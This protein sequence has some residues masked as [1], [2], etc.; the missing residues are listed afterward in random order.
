MRRHRLALAALL[1]V[2]CGG[3][4]PPAPPIGAVRVTVTWPG[5]SPETVESA[6]LTPLEQLT[7]GLPDVVRIDGQAAEGVAIVELAARTPA[8]L[9]RL[10]EAARAAL[11]DAAPRLPT[12]ASAPM[13]TKAQRTLPVLAIVPLPATDDPRRADAR[14]RELARR[15]E[16]MNGVREVDV[17]GRIDDQLQLRLDP[18]RLAAAGVTSTELMAALRNDAVPAGRLDLPGSMTTIRTTGAGLADLESLPLRPGVQLRDVATVTRAAVAP[19]V[20]HTP[21][22]RALLVTVEASSLPA[23]RAVATALRDGGAEVLPAR[24]VIGQVALPDATTAVDAVVGELLEAGAAAVRV[25]R[26]PPALEALVAAGADERALAAIDE[27]AVRRGLGAVRWAGRGVVALEALVPA[28]DLEAALTTAA[29]G[30]AE[31]TAAGHPARIEPRRAVTHEVT[32]DRVR[33]ADF[34]VSVVAVAEALRLAAGDAWLGSVHD[35]ADALDVRTAWPPG[36]DL[37]LELTVASPRVGTVPLRELVTVTAHDGPAAILH[38]DRGR[39]VAL[40]LRV[41]PGRR[42]ALTRTIRAALPTATVADAW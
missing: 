12:D 6:L 31:L 20:A 5:A 16:V 19:C 32:I 2:G 9:D 34:G 11:A 21:A 33:A 30:G 15:T 13:I 3:D 42:A 29:R 37:H 24:T 4:A 22:G 18:L 23:A 8:A 26:E 25:R 28:D 1:V 38:R 17:C 27:V 39:V 14:G 35:G 36:D 41:P 40:W 10:A 7:A